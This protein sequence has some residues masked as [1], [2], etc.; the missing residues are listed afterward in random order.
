MGAS[1]DNCKAYL[2]NV[3][4]A[5][6]IFGLAN[7]LG[8]VLFSIRVLTALPDICNEHILFQVEGP[9]YGT[10]IP[11]ILIPRYGTTTSGSTCMQVE[12][13]DAI[14]L[15]LGCCPGTD[16]FVVPRKQGSFKLMHDLFSNYFGIKQFMLPVIQPGT[17][18]LHYRGT[19]RM[20]GGESVFLSIAE[21]VVLVKDFLSHDPFESIY[22]ASDTAEF[23]DLIYNEFSDKKLLSFDQFR[24]PTGT[25]VGLHFAP[26]TNA[27]INQMS[28]AAMIDLLSLSRC[29][30]ILKTASTFSA[31]A[32]IINPSVILQ[33]VTTS[34]FR[35]PFPEDVP[36]NQYAGHSSEA[37]LILKRTLQRPQ[38][39]ESKAAEMRKMF[40][41]ARSSFSHCP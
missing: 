19:D 10:L 8:A 35:A 24:A 15:F 39:Y 22:I 33:T 14:S 34:A 11:G 26:R 2:V 7:T 32:K 4:T 16:E 5:T 9:G 27:T 37:K 40:C 21:F 31:F 38:N 25:D 6:N 30:V 1:I 3:P 36:S 41:S 28:T 13:V 20:L 18:G 12:S 29:S 17:L 23:V